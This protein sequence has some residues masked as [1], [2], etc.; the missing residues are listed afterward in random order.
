MMAGE[1]LAVWRNIPVALKRN[2]EYSLSIE[3]ML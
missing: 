3:T 2:G 1:L